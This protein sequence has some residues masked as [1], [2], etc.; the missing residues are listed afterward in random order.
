MTGCLVKCPFCNR[1]CDRDIRELNHKHECSQGHFLRGFQQVLVGNSPSI[2]TCNEIKND[3]KV[4]R[5]GQVFQ[6]EQIQQEHQNWS[7]NSQK[8]ESLQ[9]KNLQLKAW[10]E[11]VGNIVSQT[12][13]KRMNKKINI[14]KAENNNF[15][16][17]SN[18]YIFILDDSGSMQ[19]QKWQNIKQ[20]A[21]GVMNLIKDQQSKAKSS[22]IVFNTTAR[23]VLDQQF[24][25]TSTQQQYIEYQGG[26]TDYDYAFS[27]CYD[28]II[29]N[30]E[31]DGFSIQFYTDG[32]AS[33]PDVA[34]SKLRSLPQEILKKIN[35]IILTETK[36]PG[37]LQQI[38]TSL[39]SYL[40]KVQLITS[41]QPNQASLILTQDVQDQIKEV[42][43]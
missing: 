15:Y 11:G 43:N 21:I 38:V 27:M 42:I 25:N 32:E 24:I 34:I 6:W 30:F 41:V 33:V 36:S 17:D 39:E 16:Q 2:Q 26:G 8:Q 13:S 12:I 7:F 40:K 23:L 37:V 1:K 20:G 29:K 5:V 19:G 18:H 9:L 10:N 14:I 3:F 35:L 4:Q 22:V 28:Q 31:Y